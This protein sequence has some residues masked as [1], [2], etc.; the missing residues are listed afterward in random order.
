MPQVGE[1]VI[2]LE[3][4]PCLFLFAHPDD[5]CAIAGTMRQLLANGSEFHGMWVTSGGRFD[6][7]ERR[8]SELMQAMTVLGLPL[9]RVHLLRLPDLGLLDTLEDACDR[10]VRFMTEMRPAAVF[11]NAFEGGHPD[12]DAVNFVAYEARSRA[13]LQPRL[14]EFPLYNGCGPLHHWRWQIN[15]FPPSGS[16]ALYTQLDNDDIDCKYRIMRTYSSQWMFMIPAR[17]A[18]TRSRLK[19]LG[20]PYRPCPEDR[21]HTMRPHPGTLNYER[22]FN[23]F[24]KTRFDDFSRAVTS[25]RSAG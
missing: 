14:F 25:C 15:R 11:V 1:H 20:E 8:E 23:S 24:M 21:D 16:P 18:L 13:G 3:R 19:K 2:K 17:L 12:H 10:V 9:S 5:E 7:A 6:L 4:E 22:W